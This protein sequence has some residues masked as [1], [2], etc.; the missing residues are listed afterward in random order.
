MDE[1]STLKQELKCWEHMFQRKH[2]RRPNKDDVSKG[3]VEIKETYHRYRELKQITNDNQKQKE[4]QMDEDNG[5][6]GKNLNKKPIPQ[7][8]P[9][10]SVRIRD[11]SGSKPIKLCHGQ[12]SRNQRRHFCC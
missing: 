11:W 8:T 10:A 5:V 12:R 9:E 6:F 1:L 4:N 2:G 7:A 3:P